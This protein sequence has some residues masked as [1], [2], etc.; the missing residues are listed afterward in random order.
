MDVLKLILNLYLT[1]GLTCPLFSAGLNKV[2]DHEIRLSHTESMS[3]QEISDLEFKVTANIQIDPYS[4]FDYYLLAQ[5][6]IAQLDRNPANMGKIHATSEIS[7]HLLDLDPDSEFG[8][9]V[10]AQ[11]M[12]IMGYD[13]SAKQLIL[14]AMTQ[15]FSPS[16]RSYLFWQITN[17]L[18]APSTASMLARP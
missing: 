5:V 1:V 14:E 2:S 9:L 18:V 11:V 4:T 16:W 8:Y 15:K 17:Q 13:E 12:E 6:Y 3:D 7:Q 10:S